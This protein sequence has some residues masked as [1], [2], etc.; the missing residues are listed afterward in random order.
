MPKVWV[1]RADAGKLTTEFV[2]GC[3]ASIGWEMGNLTG[4]K[5]PEGIREAFEEEHPGTLKSAAANVC[6]QIDAFMNKMGA[7]DVI[8]TPTLD[9]GVI[10]FGRLAEADAYFEE[11]DAAHQHGNRRKVCWSSRYIRRTRLPDNTQ[12]ALRNLRTVFPVF[13][14]GEAFLALPAIQEATDSPYGGTPAQE[15][16]LGRIL[17]KNPGF[18][19][20]LIAELLTAMGCVQSEAVGGPGDGGVDVITQ[21]QIPFVGDVRMIVQAKRLKRGSQLDMRVVNRLKESLGQR[22]H[23]LVITTADFKPRVWERVDVD[24]PSVHLVN[25]P[26]LADELL[27][28]WR[29]LPEYFRD[30]LGPLPE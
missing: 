14:D 26:A 8:L 2:D 28:H 1:V 24:A 9:P 20:L 16:L 23:G 7:G 10:R 3:F 21:V 18:F 4:A 27:K 17:T 22:D 5:T 19:E 30:Q 15:L 25:G 12:V 6:N 13:E 11:P 29:D